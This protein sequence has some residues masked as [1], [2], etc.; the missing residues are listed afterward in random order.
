[1]TTGEHPTTGAVEV[2]GS[3]RGMG[4]GGF[5]TGLLSLLVGW[6]VPIVGVVL[7]ALG[8]VLG[9]IGRSR[10]RRESTPTGLATAGVVLGAIGLVI[11]LLVWA[12]AVAIVAN[13]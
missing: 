13:A 11:A 1:M 4:V 12:A 5:V 9:S 2:R 6:L 3:A 10:G 7:G 8:V